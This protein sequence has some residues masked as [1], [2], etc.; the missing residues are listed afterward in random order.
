VK[1]IES[2]PPHLWTKLLSKSR[3]HEFHPI[4]IYKCRPYNF[5]NM[6]FYEYFQYYELNK[7]IHPSL[8]NMEKY[9]LSFI[10]YKYEKLVIFSDFHLAHNMNVFL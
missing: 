7:M 5:E 9:S 1:S 6:T 4:D 3:F 8:N 10:I 2:K